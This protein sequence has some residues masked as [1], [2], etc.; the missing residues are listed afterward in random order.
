[1]GLSWYLQLRKLTSVLP[2][3][4]GAGSPDEER[5]RAE[6][7]PCLRPTHPRTLPEAIIRPTHTQTHTQLQPTVWSLAGGE[8]SPLAGQ[9][10]AG[11][12]RTHQILP[13]HLPSRQPACQEGRG[14][15]R[16]LLVSL[17]FNPSLSLS[18]PAA[19]P[20]SVSFPLIL[21]DSLPLIQQVSF[22]LHLP[23][24][25]PM[26][27]IHFLKYSIPFTHDFLHLSH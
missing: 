2:I 1:M 27:L 9:A 12:L 26:S 17:Q 3:S 18:L 21:G 25:L 15:P 7:T 20:V 13:H 8:P 23:P 4:A 24:C 5:I 16:T 22:P 10:S 6:G 11:S 14:E 19:Y